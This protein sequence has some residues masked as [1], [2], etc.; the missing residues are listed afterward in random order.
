MPDL[1]FEIRAVWVRPY[2]VVP[3]LVFEMRIVN[4]VAEEEVFAAALRCQVRIEATARELYWMTVAVPVPR[5]TGEKLIEVPVACYEDQVNA[6][7]KYFHAHKDGVIPLAFLF[8]VAGVDRL[9]SF[10]GYLPG[11][12]CWK[13]FTGSRINQSATVCIVGFQGR[14]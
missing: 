1:S 14:C 10:A 3:T 8:S 5:F 13:G 9:V 7:G 2:A 6:A 12:A 11:R 4:A